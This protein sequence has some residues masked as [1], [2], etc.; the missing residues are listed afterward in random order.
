[1]MWALRVIVC[2]L[3]ALALT[4]I[5]SGLIFIRALKC[6]KCGE[7]IPEDEHRSHT[8]KCNQRD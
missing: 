4:R 5:I 3:I 8:F 6:E 1:M 7:I 2:F